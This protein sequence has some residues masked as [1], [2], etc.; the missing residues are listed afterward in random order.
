MD[1]LCDQERATWMLINPERMQE[2]SQVL[3]GARAQL[4]RVE[5]GAQESGA[6][7]RFQREW[8]LSVFAHIRRKGWN[9]QEDGGRGMLSEQQES[10]PKY[11]GEGDTL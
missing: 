10:I 3:I 8:V 2:K 6:A 7:T 5:G 4:W 1:V 9:I 11:Q